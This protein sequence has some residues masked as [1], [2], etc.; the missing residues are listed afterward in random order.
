LRYDYVGANGNDWIQTPNMDALAERSWVF[1]RA[2]QSSFPTIPHRQDLIIGRYGGPFYPWRPLPFDVPTLPRALAEQGY[3]TQLIHDT[4]HLVNGGHAFDFPFHAWTFVRGAEVDRPW[5]DGKLDLPHNWGP[6]PV[7]DPIPWD[8]VYQGAMLMTYARANRKRHDY[9]DWNAA[10]LFSTAADWL[11]DNAGRD[12]F[13]LWIDGFDPHEPWD[14]PPEYA[15]MYVDDPDY[16][17]RFDPRGHLAR[18][19]SKLTD[20]AKARM[21][22]YYAAKVSWV[23]RWFG[24]V[25]RALDETGLWDNTAVVFTSDHGTNVGEWGRVGKGS[26]VRQQEAHVPLFIYVPGAG[27]GRCEHLA[28]PHDIHATVMALVQNQAP[29]SDGYDLL[30]QAKGQAE[31]ARSVTI[32]GHSVDRWRWVA[33]GRIDDPILFTVFDD[34][35][36]L[37]YA[38]YEEDCRLTELDTLEDVSEAHPDIVRRLRAQGREEIVQR[39]LDPALADW[40]AAEGEEPFPSECC[41]WNGWPGPMGFRPY[42]MRLYGGWEGPESEPER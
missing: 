20:A 11:R 39:G 38:L 12:N 19:T 24:E 42:F 3:C 27:S 21:A 9:A 40:L 36:Y 18:D 37:Q 15:K 4:P 23:D 30:A 34:T 7:F 8:N 16:D 1:D 31:P 13:F 29:E 2:F 41:F 14:V 26:P 22:A 25:T 10:K 6:D 33:E 28:Q 5:V 17:G 35:W 32:S